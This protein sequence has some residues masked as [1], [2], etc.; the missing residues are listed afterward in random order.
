MFD[1]S[2][3]DGCGVWHEGN[4]LP[5]SFELTRR[6]VKYWGRQRIRFGGLSGKSLER[7][8]QLVLLKGKLRRTLESCIY[9]TQNLVRCPEDG[10]EN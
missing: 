3:S 9:W 5:S 2:L 10:V 1:S 8:Q 7:A 6:Q 4:Q